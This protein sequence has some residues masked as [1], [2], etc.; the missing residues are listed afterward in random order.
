MRDNN[1]VYFASPFFND[2]QIER[3]ERLK[4]VLRNMGFD[5]YSPKENCLCPPNA[6]QEIR[7]KAFN[8]NLN[9]IRECSIIFVVT[10]GKDVG[11]IWEAGYA[12]GRR[13]LA[14]EERDR[15]CGMCFDEVSHV[16]VYYCETLPDGGKFNLMLAQSGDFIFTSEEQLA[17]LPRM[18]TE[19]MRVGYAGDIE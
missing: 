3:E 6:T 12:Y 15:G 17:G 19:G 16:V 18:L 2:E 8:D 5:V 1:K 14:D 9:A 4:K 11:T 10:D 7:E 13:A